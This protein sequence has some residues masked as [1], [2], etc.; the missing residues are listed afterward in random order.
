MLT[1]AG[2]NRAKVLGV[3]TL[4]FA[5]VAVIAFMPL[6]MEGKSLI[7]RIDGLCQQYG[8]FVDTGATVQRILA[9]FM[10]GK[11]LHLPFYDFSMG[12]GSVH[13]WS[14]DPFQYLSV[15]CASE[16]TEWLFNVL[17]VVRL[18]LVGAC[19]LP[20]MF[21]LGATN[22]GAVL[23]ALTYAFSGSGLNCAL[24]TQYLN[25]MILLP[26][27]VYSALV[28]LDVR[29]PWPYILSGGAFCFVCGPYLYYSSQLLVAVLVVV[30]LVVRRAS[31]RDWL[32]FFVLFAGCSVLSMLVACDRLVE[33]ARIASLDRVKVSYVT[34]MLYSAEY[35][36]KLFC[37]FAGVA[38][39]GADWFY[40][41][42]ACG[43][44]GV[45]ALWV[46]AADRK[47][48]VLRILFV[49]GLVFL[50][51]PFI[52]S[53]FNGFAYVA[54]RWV[55]GFALLVA[56]IVGTQM[57]RL[58]VID[59]K[60]LTK[61]S[62]IL[63]VYCALVLV[64]P[65]EETVQTHWQMVAAWALIAFLVLCDNTLNVAVPAA[66]C[67]VALGCNWALFFSPS[68]TNW[69][70]RLVYQG[71]AYA[72]VATETP[73]GLASRDA[74][75]S[76]S[77]TDRSVAL[78][79]DV[80]TPGLLAH[81]LLDT[82]G[83]DY[84]SSV[85]NND[86]D[87]F[88]RDMALAF[89]DLPN[90]YYTLDQRA[91]LMR[92]LGVGTYVTVPQDRIP[93]PYGVKDEVVAKLKTR[94]DD[95]YELYDEES[96]S[97]LALVYDDAIASSAYEQLSPLQKQEALLQGVVLDD[98][99]AQAR[100]LRIPTITSEEVGFSV[101]EIG[102]GVQIKDG[103]VVV[104]KPSAYMRIRPERALKD[105]E[106]YLYVEGLELDAMSPREQFT[107]KEWN[108]LSRVEQKK[109]QREEEA[110]TE[111]KAFRIGVKSNRSGNIAD[112]IS[113][114]HF[115]LYGGKDTWLWNAGYCDKS[116]RRLRLTF[117]TPGVYS[118]DDFKVLTQPMDIYD[119]ATE[120][121]TTRAVQDMRITDDTLTCEVDANAGQV[122]FLSIPYDDCWSATVN[123]EEVKIHK[124]DTAFMA[125]DLVEGKNEIE[126]AFKSNARY[127]MMISFA[128]TVACLVAW[129]W[130]RCVRKTS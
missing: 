92:V 79:N 31:F 22:R 27:V 100:S 86:V 95:E 96:P 40:G 82:Y 68:G 16:N 99:D 98:E 6:L 61:L 1:R 97:T 26:V 111:P 54:N 127:M 30:M 125:I 57:E 17:V 21:K 34:P 70:S 12:Y 9:D 58:E 108:K 4:A 81:R 37:G 32:R 53:A 5:A 56:C 43:L 15:F 18:W 41:Y 103:T 80:Q 78:A 71:D 123:G 115:H 91:A 55:F 119:D 2:G 105:C 88:H 110:W 11:G 38:S 74:S 76:T 102:D 50:C 59:A 48:L 35:Y 14:H 36:Q 49:I 25:A 75:V 73:A 89:S 8:T 33:I 114:P 66:I 113:T 29:N 128:A 51:V 104:S 44:L 101:V 42:G 126:F 3:Y 122:L 72:L 106:V 60:R 116:I 129:G 94:N 39:G 46:G 120:R 85:Y 117:Y 121:F 130:S 23:G 45:L 84:Y 65:Y 10:A 52:G 47:T 93:L 109:V 112:T 87:A 24:Q 90:T 20:L 69:Q 63:L 62:V 83:I 13:N 28:L 64:L 77:R 124:A 67:L 118:F 7:N 107:Q 19:A